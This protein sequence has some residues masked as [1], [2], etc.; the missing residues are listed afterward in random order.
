VQRVKESNAITSLISSIFSSRMTTKQTK[1]KPA[2]VSEST[3]S[4]RWRFLATFLPPVFSASRVQQVS[5]LHLKFALRPRHGC[6]P[7]FHSWCGLSANSECR[8]ETCCMRLAENTGRKKVAK[9]RHLR[10]IA[11]FCRAIS[12][13]LR[14]IS[15]IGKKLVKQRYVLHMSS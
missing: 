5:L 10:T 15:T 4:T 6:L 11:Q 2:A 12:S 3:S 13:Q 9:H 7:Y 14:H 1:V 8:S